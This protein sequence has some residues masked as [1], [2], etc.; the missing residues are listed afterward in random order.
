MVGLPNRATRVEAAC[1]C[2]VTAL[3]A[4]PDSDQVLVLYVTLVMLAVHDACCWGDNREGV[5]V[6]NS[7]LLHGLQVG[8]MVCQEG[9]RVLAAETRD[10]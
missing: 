4:H 5:V 2:A 9:C 3:A 7:G 10:V 8:F 1:S 6:P